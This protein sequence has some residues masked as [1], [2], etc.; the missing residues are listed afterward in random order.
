[1]ISQQIWPL[2]LSQLETPSSSSQIS[3]LK[4]KW[5]HSPPSQPMPT[6]S[7]LLHLSL[8]KSLMVP[9]CIVLLLELITHRIA[10][11][12]FPHSSLLW[13]AIG[14]P[15]KSL[16]WHVNQ[17]HL[18]IMSHMGGFP[19]KVGS[20][21]HRTH[22]SFLFFSSLSGCCIILVQRCPIHW[23]CGSCC[24]MVSRSAN[25]GYFQLTNM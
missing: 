19:W 10:A 18:L 17:D 21:L 1:M 22:W 25:T 2:Q 24:F 3:N 16:V 14:M 4:K 23:I 7:L 8:M 20:H 12:S 9:L 11:I 6:M 15:Y 5:T 13:V